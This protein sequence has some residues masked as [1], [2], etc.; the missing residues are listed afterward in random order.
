MAD[1]SSWAAVRD[2]RMAEPTARPAYDAARLA[3]ELGRT[4]RQLRE[5]RGWNQAELAKAMPQSAVA[6]FEAGER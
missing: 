3:Y 1:R 6:R 4:V 5:T 2:R